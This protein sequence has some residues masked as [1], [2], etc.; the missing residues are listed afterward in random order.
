MTRVVFFWPPMVSQL[1]FTR[2]PGRDADIIAVSAVGE[3]T[4][5]PL[6][7]VITSPLTSPAPEAPVPHSTPS[8]R[9][10]ELAGAMEDGTV[11]SASSSVQP[12]FCG[13]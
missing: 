4:A 2:L 7:A 13:A 6:T 3:V 1:S 10:P 9:A 8:T 11:V 5:C 12:V